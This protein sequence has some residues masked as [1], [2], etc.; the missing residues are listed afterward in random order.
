MAISPAFFSSFRACV[1]VSRDVPTRSARS[2]W[3][4]P[5]HASELRIQRET[6]DQG[7]ESSGERFERQ[8]LELRFGFAQTVGQSLHDANANGWEAADEVFE[9]P[10]ADDTQ[11][12]FRG[13]FGE[14]VVNRPVASNAIS[15]KNIPGS[16]LKI[17]NR[18]PSG[19]M[20]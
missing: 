5:V 16:M 19:E 20:R 14:R 17:T 3:V 9:V 12:R 11:R 7:S 2:L 6:Q 10:S 1:A 18:L 8:I 15:P 13:R 4:N